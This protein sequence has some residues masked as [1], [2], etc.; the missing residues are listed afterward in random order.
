[1]NGNVYWILLFFLVVGFTFFYTMVI[2]QQQ[3]LAE[4]LQ[5]QGGFIPGI[6]PGRPTSDY[7]NKTIVR[8]LFEVFDTQNLSLLDE[9]VAQDYIDH[10]RQFR[11]LENYKQHLRLFYKSFPDSHEAIEDIIA[12]GDRVWVRYRFTGTHHGEYRRLAPTGKIVTFT[13]V[14]TWRIAGGK[15]VEKVSALY[16]VLDFYRQ[17][18]VIEYKGFP[19]EVK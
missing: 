19:D 10:P 15:A 7:L 11:G 17:L 5:K 18:G 14:A 4:T 13:A 16:N 8:K 12:E 2:F 1:V 3:N 9:F 6:R